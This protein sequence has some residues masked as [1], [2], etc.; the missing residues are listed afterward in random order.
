MPAF[1]PSRHRNVHLF[2]Y[3]RLPIFL[4]F[5]H[6]FYPPRSALA[7]SYSSYPTLV[8]LDMYLAWDSLLTF[9]VSSILRS[10]RLVS[11]SLP[12]S[13][14]PRP[15]ALILVYSSLLP[16]PISS[17]YQVYLRFPTARK[18]KLHSWPFLLGIFAVFPPFLAHLFSVC[19]IVCAACSFSPHLLAFCPYETTT[20]SSNVLCAYIH[21][22]FLT[23]SIHH[24]NIVQNR[25]FSLAFAFF[26]VQSM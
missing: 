26:I 6:L 20:R 23:A 24:H 12:Y 18:I 22:H 13:L 1:V 5:L 21:V 25:S 14:F 10:I 2:T 7:Y 16:D 4:F 8:L 15:N 11:S 3:L 9:R 19:T 17:C